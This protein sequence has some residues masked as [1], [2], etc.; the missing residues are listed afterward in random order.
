MKK[1]MKHAKYW[2]M[3]KGGYV[4]DYGYGY[5]I[6]FKTKSELMGYAKRQNTKLTHD[7]TY[8]RHLSSEHKKT[9]YPKLWK[10]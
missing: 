6:N 1:G 10:R 3:R 8:E 7:Y 9:K 4:L 2:K 5:P